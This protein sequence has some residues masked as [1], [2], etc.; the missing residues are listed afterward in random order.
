VL[1]AYDVEPLAGTVTVA[2]PGAFVY[3]AKGPIGVAD[4]VAVVRCIHP[5]ERRPATSL[6]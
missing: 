4:A 2:S 6:R 5:C 1:S 3:G